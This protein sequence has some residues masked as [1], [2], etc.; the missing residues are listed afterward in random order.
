MTNQEPKII[1]EYDTLFALRT[2]LTI[3]LQTVEEFAGSADS[4]TFELVGNDTTDILIKTKN[5][6]LL[7]KGLKKE[8]LNSAVSQGFIMFYEMDGDEFV[9]NTTCSYIK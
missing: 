2:G 9:R 7:L 5:S 3:M 8:I 4:S 6:P 1:T